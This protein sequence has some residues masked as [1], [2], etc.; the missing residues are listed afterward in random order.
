M[1][2]LLLTL[3]TPN[4]IHAVYLRQF[5]DAQAALPAS[6]FFTIKKTTTAIFISLKNRGFCGDKNVSFGINCTA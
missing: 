5:I 6:S 2:L 3:L 4:P 1:P